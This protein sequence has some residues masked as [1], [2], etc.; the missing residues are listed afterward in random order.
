[1]ICLRLKNYEENITRLPR[2][3][4]PRAITRFIYERKASMRGVK[5]DLSGQ[6][7]GRWEVWFRAPRGKS[8]DARYVCA[9]DCGVIKV[10]YALAL[11]KGQ[12]TSC[13]CYCVEV[14]KKLNTVHGHTAGRTRSPLFITWSGMNSR[15]FN[16]NDK[17]YH[18]Y[19]G[20]GITI[21][22]RWRVFANFAADMVS[23]PEGKSIDRIENDLN[24][25]CGKCDHCIRQGWKMNVKWSTPPE[26][27]AP[28]RRRPRKPNKPK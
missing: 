2:Q 8:Y 18:D 19:G 25:S 27:T 9:C 28:G 16:P 4:Y 24:Y 6:R 1:M 26:Q 21:C 10:V 17:R 7:F 15:C 12:S 11:K 13:G 22:D 20:R 23:R 14:A 5:E 3:F